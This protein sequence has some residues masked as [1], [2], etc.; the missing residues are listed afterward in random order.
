M[1]GTLIR[2][3]LRL[4][5]IGAVA[6]SAFAAAAARADAATT[7]YTGTV[8]Q[9]NLFGCP[10]YYDPNVTGYNAWKVWVRA[11]QIASDPRLKY[12]EV[13]WEADLVSSAQTSPVERV[14]ADAWAYPT[15]T[16]P[17]F[18]FFNTSTLLP[19][20]ATSSYYYFNKEITVNDSTEGGSYFHVR[21]TVWFQQPNGSWVQGAQWYSRQSDGQDSCP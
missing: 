5:L 8:Y 13:A 16:A 4:A 18:Y 11:P 3:A 1:K 9:N 7:V 17:S 19:R 21:N 12:Q 14:L 2:Q 15:V 10:N 6:L 20:D